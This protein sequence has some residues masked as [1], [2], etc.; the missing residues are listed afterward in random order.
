MITL[1]FDKGGGLLPAIAQDHQTGE[2]LMM[3]YINEESWQRTLASG[4]VHYWSRSRNRIWLKGESSG[5]FLNVKEIRIDCDGDALL[6]KCDP[7]G[8]TCHTNETSCFYRKVDDEGTV[9]LAGD[10]VATK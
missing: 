6:V 8:P 7:V 10:G 4:K 9:Q 1:R 5:H 2:V 3:A